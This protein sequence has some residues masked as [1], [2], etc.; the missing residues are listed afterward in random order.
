MNIYK[1]ADLIIEMDSG[2]IITQSQSKKYFAPPGIR[3]DFL[4]D[5]SDKDIEVFVEMNPHL[6]RDEAEYLLSGFSFSSRLVDYDG[7]CLHASAIAFENSA[8][9][10]SAPCGT[11]K[12][13]QSRLWGE[14][15]GDDKVT[16]INDDKPAIRYVDGEFY[17]YGTPWSGKCD[18]NHN[19]RVPLKA[20]CFIE[21]SEKNKICRLSA[22]EAVVMLIYQSLRPGGRNRLERLLTLIDKMISKTQIYKMGC[23]MSDEAVKMAYEAIFSQLEGDT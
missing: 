4:I 18:L 2:G 21:Q 3:P 1:I 17:V 14:Y 13:T 19:M 23:T 22:K 11:G 7:F 16:V 10:F 20:V 5:T 8:I 9:L 6:N 12:S 15:F